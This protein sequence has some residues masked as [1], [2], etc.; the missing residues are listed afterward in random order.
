MAL[1]RQTFTVT[2]GT[3]GNTDPVIDSPAA[4]TLPAAGPPPL[5]VRVQAHDDDADPLNYYLAGSDGC[6]AGGR[7][8]PRPGRQLEPRPGWLVTFGSG[9]DAARGRETHLY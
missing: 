3:G 9:A 1:R 7:I 4:G 2:V 6:S 5:P 8:D